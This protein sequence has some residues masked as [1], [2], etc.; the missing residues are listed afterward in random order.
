MTDRRTSAKDAVAEPPTTDGAYMRARKKVAALCDS[1]P[2]EIVIVILVIAYVIFTF[3]EMSIDP[4]FNKQIETELFLI[5][6]VLLSMFMV[7]IV[8]KLFAFQL[9][10]LRS[11]ANS[12]DAAVIVAS[13]IVTLVALSSPSIALLRLFRL[14]VVFRV[15]RLFVLMNRFRRGQRLLTTIRATR[16]RKGISSPVDRVIVI[17]RDLKEKFALE[18]TDADE[19]DWIIHVVSTNTLYKAVLSDAAE[20][21]DVDDDTHA[22]LAGNFSAQVRDAK[23]ERKPRHT[24]LVPA[25]AGKVAPSG[26]DALSKGRGSMLK[27]DSGMRHLA[28]VKDTA[29]L[30]AAL[31]NLESLEFDTFLLDEAAEGHCL[32]ATLL[33]TM[34]RH[35]MLVR[36]AIDEETLMRF[37]AAIEDGYSHTTPYHNYIHGTDVLQKM[38]CYLS[39]DRLREQILDIDVLAC[40]VGA[41]VH[42]YEHPGFNNQ[43]Q[44]NVKSSVATIYNDRSVLENHHASVTFHILADE[45][46]DLLMCLQEEE[47]RAIRNT[48]IACI[49]STDMK[50][51]YDM[52]TG[53]NARE[54]GA[55]FSREVSEDRLALMEAVVHCAD[56][57]AQMLP[58]H[59][60]ARWGARCVEEFR[61]QAAAEADAGLPVTAFMENLDDS[62]TVAKLQLNFIDFVVQP[63]WT[64]L[65]RLF[66]RNEHLLTNLASN[67]A[68]YQSVVDEYSERR[69]S[70]VLPVS[71]VED[72]SGDGGIIKPVALKSPSASASAVTKS[73]LSLS[74]EDPSFHAVTAAEIAADLAS[75]PPAP[76]LRVETLSPDSVGGIE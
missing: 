74:E 6:F 63:I 43:F 40:L 33:T 35:E 4:E 22:W 73:S 48:V 57:G 14:R 29:K 2:F 58:P 8:L 53:L 60:A 61:T 54:P 28:G 38:H 1:M 72:V 75:K 69:R 13:F 59:V 34:K 41:V 26:E 45:R 11:W 5:D 37:A 18:D 10:Y 3:F 27:A 65:T 46:N 19:V 20:G 9:D 16:A 36:M 55:A 25:S 47:R 7:E 24:V 12:L 71:V 17:L 42:D 31:S 15:L 68:S 52:V 23:K 67:R 56:I 51:H 70:G 44:I 49:L 50:M 76:A 21:G 32:I 62:V 64:T 66:P 30:E 39:V